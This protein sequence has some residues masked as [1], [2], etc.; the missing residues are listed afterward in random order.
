MKSQKQRI[1]NMD[2]KKEITP[3]TMQTTDRGPDIYFRLS[4]LIQ[5]RI[6]WDEDLKPAI[7]TLANEIAIRL[8]ALDLANENPFRQEDKGMHPEDVEDLTEFCEHI[9]ALTIE[10]LKTLGYLTDE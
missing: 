8:D 6:G 4:G 9:P 3:P 10:D 2:N 7:E 1:F 5:K